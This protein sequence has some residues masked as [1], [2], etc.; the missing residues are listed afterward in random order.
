MRRLQFTLLSL[1][2]AAVLSVPAAIAVAAAES[3]PAPAPGW[4]QG[5]VIGLIA[6]VI[7]AAGMMIDAV[8][9]VL[10][11]VAPRTK[12]KWDDDAAAALDRLHDR[13]AEVE[14]RLPPTPPARTPLGPVA[15]IALV[16][17]GLAGAGASSLSCTAAQRTDLGNG[18]KAAVVDCTAA[19]AGA[20]AATLAAM[21][22]P[23]DKGGCYA[24]RVTDWKCVRGKAIN[25]GIAI[26]GCAFLEIVSS[27]SAALRGLAAVGPADSGRDAFEEYRSAVAGGARFRTNTGEH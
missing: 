2:A 24:D 1:L 5:E 4:S 25:A 10:H 12:T 11:F 7:S 19:S 20:I 18:A 22:A 3:P 9:G 21:R 6:L 17:L 27:S 23:V 15:V 16:L 26:G 8:R 13:I 14:A